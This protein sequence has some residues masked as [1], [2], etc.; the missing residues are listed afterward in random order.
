MMTMRAPGMT[1]ARMPVF[2]WSMAVTQVLVLF[3]VPVLTAALAMLYTDRH[4]GTTFFDPRGGGNPILWQHLFW[5]YSHPAVYIMILP[6][7]GIISEVLPVFSHKPLFGRKA[8]IYS[9]VAIGVLGFTFDW[10]LRQ[11][12]RRILYW[13]PDQTEKLRAL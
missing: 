4:L 12:Q 9:S 2:V 11:A 8:V 3:A 1:L 5:F 7:F 10:L 13:L 6:A